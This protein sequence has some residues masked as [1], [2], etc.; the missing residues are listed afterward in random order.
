MGDS[1]IAGEFQSFRVDHDEFDLVGRR[2]E[3]DAADHGVQGDALSG[4]GRAGDQQVRHSD[5]FGDQRRPHDVFAQ[6]DRKTV[7]GFPKGRVIEDVP[8]A[9]RFPLL[10]GDLNADCPSSRDR[11]DD[12]NARGA[13]RERQIVGEIRDFIDLDAGG[14][15]K[16]IHRDDRAGL[17]FDHLPV[18]AEVGELLFEQPGVGDQGFPLDSNIFPLQAVQQGQGRQPEGSVQPGDEI[19]M[20]LLGLLQLLLQRF[21]SWLFDDRGRRRRRFFYDRRFRVF[22][23][24]LPE[25]IDPEFSGSR[26]GSRRRRGSPRKGNYG[27]IE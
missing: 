1:L 21:P 20:G 3:Q 2:L 26:R 24:P 15:F 16:L 6:R 17:D 14:G 25:P 23:Q 22:P 10:I 11:G 18:D 5:Q 9:D 19:E 7:G 12:P 27:K 4:A 13:Q 8:Q